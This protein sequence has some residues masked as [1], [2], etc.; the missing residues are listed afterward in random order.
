VAAGK[1]KNRVSRVP[2]LYLDAGRTKKKQAA[3]R[4]TCLLLVVFLNRVLLDFFSSQ[5]DKTDQAA[6]QQD[7]GYR[8][9]K[10]SGCLRRVITTVL[11]IDQRIETGVIH[12]TQENTVQ[13]AIWFS[14][15]RTGHIPGRIRQHFPME[16]INCCDQKYHYQEK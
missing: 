7:H 4:W 10:G 8:I 5:T 16:Q 14:T 12:R 2:E 3:P 15:Q 11:D 6:A 9:Q 13:Y 1:N